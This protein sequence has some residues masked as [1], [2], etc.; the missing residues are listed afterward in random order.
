M[1]NIICKPFVY[2][3]QYLRNLT[4]CMFHL[5]LRLAFCSVKTINKDPIPC[6]TL[7]KFEFFFTSND[8]R[9]MNC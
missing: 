1:R 8:N 7:I 3:Y 6:F 2:P 9:K 4:Y 5:S